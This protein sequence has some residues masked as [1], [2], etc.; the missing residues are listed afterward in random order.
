[1]LLLGKDYR[2][3]FSEGTPTRVWFE[4]GIHRVVVP[5]S[6]IE[7]DMPETQEQFELLISA[8][9]NGPL[10]VIPTGGDHAV[11]NILDNDGNANL[12]RVLCK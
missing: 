2:I 9:S 5:I 10:V 8:P 6:I 7:D 1:M 11:V 3:D 12:N 4:P